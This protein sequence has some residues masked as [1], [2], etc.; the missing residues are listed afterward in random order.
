MDCLTSVKI[1][2]PRENVKA[3]MGQEY[4]RVQLNIAV[5]Y[6]VCHSRID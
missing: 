3:V 2:I 1:I 4:H 5:L 6:N